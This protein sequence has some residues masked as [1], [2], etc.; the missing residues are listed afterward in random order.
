VR[1][2]L[3]GIET[4]AGVR[5][6]EPSGRTEAGEPADHDRDQAEDVQ[7][8]GTAVARRSQI[9]SWTSSD[10]NGVNKRHLLAARGFDPGSP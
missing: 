6:P 5:A 2:V 1:T 8:R 3:T 4:P 7:R 9:R 10:P